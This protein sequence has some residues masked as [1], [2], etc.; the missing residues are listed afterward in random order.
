MV[1]GALLGALAGL[2]TAQRRGY[3]RADR[4]AGLYCYNG[5]LIGQHRPHRGLRSSSTWLKPLSS[6]VAQSGH[7]LTKF[8]VYM[9]SQQG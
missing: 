6:A 5:V 7:G 4:Q 9:G 2:L 3:D 1:G 8:L